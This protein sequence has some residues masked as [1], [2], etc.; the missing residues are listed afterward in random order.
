MTASPQSIYRVLCVLS[1]DCSR[2]TIW[3]TCFKYVCVF[4]SCQQAM[5]WCAFV[6]FRILQ[7]EQR[8]IKEAGFWLTHA[9]VPYHI[10]HQ[11]RDG[12]VRE[13][14]CRRAVEAGKVVSDTLCKQVLTAPVQT[15]SS[16]NWSW[17]GPLMFARRAGDVQCW[18]CT[19]ALLLICIVACLRF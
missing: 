19:F 18:V 14:L 10:R 8:C 11:L 9:N 7:S 4:F 12:W 1:L 17:Y 15:L 16:A 5:Y 13:I 2:S 3:C 6:A